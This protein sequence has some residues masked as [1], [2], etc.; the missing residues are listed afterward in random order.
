M[1]FGNAVFTSKSLNSELKLLPGLISEDVLLH[2]PLPNDWP[3]YL[4]I[5]IVPPP[6]RFFPCFLKLTQNPPKKWKTPRWGIIWEDV[7][8]SFP[9]HTDCLI[10]PPKHPSPPSS[11][12]SSSNLTSSY[13]SPL[14][15]PPLFKQI[16]MTIDEKLLDELIKDCFLKI[17]SFKSQTAEIRNFKRLKKIIKVSNLDEEKN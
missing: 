17:I 6:S 4:I 8:F 7:L 13:F 5:N 15:A 10:S 1:L 14:P 3:S 2:C 12:F 9:P 16:C 11:S